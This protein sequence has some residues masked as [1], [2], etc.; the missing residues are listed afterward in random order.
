[1]QGDAVEDCLG[2]PAVE[3]ALADVSIART[4]CGRRRSPG[5]RSVVAER[6]AEAADV[7]ARLPEE[8]R[9]RLL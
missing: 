6:L 4:H 1:M 9:A 8:R 3:G 2:A 7:L 5:H